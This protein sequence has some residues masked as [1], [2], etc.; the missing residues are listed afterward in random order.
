MTKQQ[1]R[2]T[3]E[4]SV[5]DASSHYSPVSLE[6]DQ[7]DLVLGE[8]SNIPSPST[9]LFDLSDMGLIT[10]RTNDSS[11]PESMAA[12]SVK[13]CAFPD[14]LDFKEHGERELLTMYF[15]MSITDFY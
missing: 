11:I 14:V 8:P 4:G 6:F 15:L 5:V 3:S 13:Q 7:V 1:E 12:S 10:P 2:T 9:G